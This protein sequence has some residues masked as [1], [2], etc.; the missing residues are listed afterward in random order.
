GRQ[1]SHFNPAATGLASPRPRLAL[2]MPFPSPPPASATV[3]AGGRGGKGMPLIG[4]VLPIA[5]APRGLIFRAHYNLHGARRKPTPDPQNPRTPP[6]TGRL[7]LFSS[8]LTRMR[9][10]CARPDLPVWP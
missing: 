10:P 6:A 7:S 9:I 3:K 4:R 1:P 8:L 2:P 5:T